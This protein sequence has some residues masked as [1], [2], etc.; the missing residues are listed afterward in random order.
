MKILFGMFFGGV[1]GFFIGL[2]GKA[3]DGP[4]PIGN[5]P[6]AT[7][8]IGAVLGAAIAAGR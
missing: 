2:F 3:T 4:F 7:A 5:N 1:I 8:I 6:I